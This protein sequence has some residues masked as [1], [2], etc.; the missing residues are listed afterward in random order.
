MKSQSFVAA[1]L[2]LGLWA[3]VADA[4]NG[5][6]RLDGRV[7]NDAQQ[8][9]VDRLCAEWNQ[10]DAPGVNIAVSR[11]GVVLYERAFG[12]ANLELSVPLKRESVFQ[13][14]SVAKQFTAMSI[15]LLQQ[16]GRLSIDDEVRK[17]LPEFPDYG[18]P[19]TIRHLLNHTSGIRD[20]H[21]LHQALAAPRDDIGDWNDILVRR[22][23]AQRGLNFPPGSDFQYNNGGYVLLATIVK[24]VSG[25]SLQDFAHENIFR[26]L[27]MSRTRFDD[28]PHRLVPNRVTGHARDGDAWR[29]AR[30]EVTR[31]GSVGNS[32]L[33]STASDLLRWE[34]NFVDGTVGGKELVAAMETPA[35]LTSGPALPYGLGLWIT[36]DRG[37][38]TVHHG[39][40]AP[41]FAAQTIRYP[42]QGLAIVVLAN[43]GR[44]DASALA[45]RISD[46]YLG[47]AALPSSTPS[48]VGP[49]TGTASFTDEQLET[50][51]GLYRDIEGSRFIRLFVRDR[52]LMWSRGTGTRG[53]LE[54]VPLAEDRFVIPGTFPLTFEFLAERPGTLAFRASSPGQRSATF[55]RLAP[56]TPSS[57]ERRQYT[58]DYASSELDV[59]YTIV[60]EGGVLH[61][62]IRERDEPILLE[63]AGRDLFQ[64]ERGEAFTFRR[65]GRGDI[66]GFVFSS[67]GA[68]SL[69]FDRGTR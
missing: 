59:T 53:G 23:A 47:T 48:A 55:E 8:A 56:F 9:E 46:V 17:H 6:S 43:S 41:G 5:Q 22:L 57:A 50:K 3:S 61:V 67:N 20:V 42:D 15:L 45:A 58:G 39:G 33:L 7:V 19:L 52:R 28:D 64:T 34:H 2:A 51:A 49:G 37:R 31:P 27:G 10:P 35:V 1:S 25:R 40:G 32:G 29:R 30:E 44:F 54:M 60:E 63:P 68:W 13:V 11:D 12:T 62:R 21:L 38:R 66:D 65:D 16:R 26:P 24:R 14:A 18:T 69:R 4:A 36:D